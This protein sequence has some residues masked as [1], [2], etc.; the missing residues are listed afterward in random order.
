MSSD[1]VFASLSCISDKMTSECRGQEQSRCHDYA[2]Q[3]QK[4]ENH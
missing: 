2:N 4:A 1:C 3:Q